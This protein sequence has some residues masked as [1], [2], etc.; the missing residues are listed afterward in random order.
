[1][2]M[3]KIISLALALIMAFSCFA[4]LTVSADDGAS[5]RYYGHQRTTAVGDTYGIRLIALVD[6]LSPEAVG[7]DIAIIHE[8][9]SVGKYT[10]EVKSVYTS[11][12]GTVDGVETEI[13]ADTLGGK[14]ICTLVIGGIPANKGYIGVLCS[15]YSR[16]GETKIAGTT[17]Q[18]IYNGAENWTAP[19]GFETE[20]GYAPVKAEYMGY[21][22]NGTIVTDYNFYGTLWN[23]TEVAYMWDGQVNN[24]HCYFMTW[25][26]ANATATSTAKLEK[27][28]V[29]GKILLATSA[30]YDKNANVNI[31]ASVDGEK[32]DVLYTIPAGS[33]FVAAGTDGT[34]R[35]MAIEINND[36]AYNYVRAKDAGITGFAFSEVL[37]YEKL[38]VPTPKRVTATYLDYGDGKGGKE[39]KFIYGGDVNGT[40][41]NGNA[42][43][44]KYI[45]DG[46]TDTAYVQYFNWENAG[47]YITAKLPENTVISKITLATI[48]MPIRNLGTAIQASVDGE[49]WVTLYT[50]SAADGSFAEGQNEWKLETLD[51]YVNDSTPYNYIRVYDTV[52]NGY[53]LAEV[54][55]YTSECYNVTFGT[56]LETVKP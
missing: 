19:D 40:S 1:M 11:I 28:T 47:S 3:R 35:T 10:K 48:W 5:V 25:G 43:G 18:V 29:I 6:D 16:T 36:T 21:S 42:E 37:V 50:V 34:L 49:E 55:V 20:I 13:K 38:S 4:A 41:L 44:L 7:F 17:Q 15:V 24:N 54:E 51:I 53:C 32:W 33:D 8:D 56:L 12:V 23:D 52:L 2:K 22:A 45:F 14:Y 31:E 30:R 26:Q 46:V 39:T 9:G 27:S